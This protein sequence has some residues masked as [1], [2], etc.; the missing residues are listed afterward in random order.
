MPSIAPEASMYS[1]EWFPDNIRTE[2]IVIDRI[3]MIDERVIFFMGFC[4]ID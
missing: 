4:L 2:P 1:P 3:V